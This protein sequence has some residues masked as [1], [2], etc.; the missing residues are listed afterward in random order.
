M[1]CNLFWEKCK[2]FMSMVFFLQ[3]WNYTT[4]KV[5]SCFQ[6]RNAQLQFACMHM[7]QGLMQ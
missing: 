1:S 4:W 7:E 2:L 6:S 5:A 3:R